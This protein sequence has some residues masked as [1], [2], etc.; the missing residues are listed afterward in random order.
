MSNPKSINSRNEK[1]FKDPLYGYISLPVNFVDTFIDTPV[2]Q[3][4]RDIVQTSYSSLYAATL[5]NRFIHSL[6]V[7]HLGCIA[8]KNMQNSINEVIYKRKIDNFSVDEHEELFMAACLLHDVGHAPFSHIGEEFYEKPYGKESLEN[9][10]WEAAG[11]AEDKYK[12]VN[13]HEIAAPHEKMSA[14]VA[15]RVFKSFFEN[16]DKEFFA[17]CITGYKYNVSLYDKKLKHQLQLKNCL[18]SILKSEPIDVDRLDYLIRDSFVSGYQNV[19]I[20]YKRLLNGLMV[21]YDNK[22]DEYIPAFHKNA[23]SIIE[24]VIFAHDSERK[25]IQN[26]PVICYEAEIIKY[27]IKRIITLTYNNISIFCREALM[28]EG[29][30]VNAELHL[31]NKLKITLLSDTDVLFYIKNVLYEDKFLKELF[32][33]AKRRNALWK[34]EVEFTHLY[35]AKLSKD[36]IKSIIEICKSINEVFSGSLSHI[37]PVINENALTAAT[38]ILNNYKNRGDYEL[39]LDEKIYDNVDEKRKKINKKGI[40]DFITY[41]KCFKKFANDNKLDFNIGFMILMPDKFKSNFARDKT[42]NIRIWFPITQRIDY[43]SNITSTLIPTQNSETAPQPEETNV[44]YFYTQKIKN[45]DEKRKIQEKFISFI[46]ENLKKK[47][48]K[49]SKI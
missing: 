8:F 12:M 21:V 43:F 6:G 45:N 22:K 29:V 34:S 37:P 7:Y 41:C 23:V 48:E 20:D 27:A 32:D 2:F 30:V 46:E 47:Y 19:S 14:I 13:P 39:Y 35:S 49:L 24:S 28:E 3:R 31:N 11:V 26:H 16:K 4:L 15:L 25:W 9:Q 44:I 33:R 5:H 17:R 42:K 18:I 40:T 1:I 10:F 36:A 38:E